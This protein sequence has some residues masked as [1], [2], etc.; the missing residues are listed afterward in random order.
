M[1]SFV[2]RAAASVG[3]LDGASKS[4]KPQKLSDLVKEENW[5]AMRKPV[6]HSK[7][8][9]RMSKIYITRYLI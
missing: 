7:A 8:S 2:R 4:G 9:L 1:F 3:A 6:S 5:E